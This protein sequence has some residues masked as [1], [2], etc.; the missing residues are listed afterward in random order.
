MS[1][2]TVCQQ[3][4]STIGIERPTSVIGSTER[5]HQELAD[6]AQE[7]A[8]QL[9]E[10]YPWQRLKV[11]ETITGDGETT[12]F[13]LPDDFGWIPEGQKIKSVTSWGDYTHVPD[14]NDWLENIVRP[15]QTIY[16]AWTLLG[17][18]LHFNPALTDGAEAKFYYVSKNW[19]L[20]GSNDEQDEFTSNED[21]FLL[22][23]TMLRLCMGW[24]W[25]AY[26]KLPYQEEL[27]LF[28][29]D[30][31]KRVA[32]DKGPRGF[33]MGKRGLYGVGGGSASSSADA[34][35]AFPFTLPFEIS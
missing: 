6:I 35:T 11:L 31:A 24:K 34:S 12:A 29:D 25:K 9:A 28:G 19:C 16:S 14:H 22:S 5:E 23:E 4:S 13:D 27:A 7:C 8:Q 3:L 17:G 33:A 10:A 1:I 30:F 18:Q 32:R 21:S 20:S 15:F 26:K 2:L